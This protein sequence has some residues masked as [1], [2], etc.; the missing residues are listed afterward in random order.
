MLWWLQ[1]LIL[2]LMNPLKT[3]IQEMYLYLS[4]LFGLYRGLSPAAPGGVPPSFLQE[5]L[6]ELWCTEWHWGILCWEHLGLLCSLSFHQYWM[7]LLHEEWAVGPLETAL[8]PWHLVPHKGGKYICLIC[9]CVRSLSEIIIIII[10]IIIKEL[11]KTAI[12]GTAHILR[13]VLT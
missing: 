10:I 5:P 8:L 9:G 6:C 11:L 2:W 13:K 4:C 3:R 1:C 12:L 7:F